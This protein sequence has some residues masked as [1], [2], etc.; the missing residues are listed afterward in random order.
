VAGKNSPPFGA[1]QIR[2]ADMASR[3]TNATRLV[4]AIRLFCLVSN[5]APQLAYPKS[6][7]EAIGCGPCI[8]GGLLVDFFGDPFMAS[9]IGVRLFFVTML[10]SGLFT[11]PMPACCVVP[12]F[13]K[14]VVN[15]DQTVVIVWDAA[16]R[17]QHFIRKASFQSEAD[18]FGFIVPSP[19]QPELEESGN[20]A[21]PYLQTLTEPKVIKLPRPI[22]IGCGH[23][24]E[25]VGSAPGSSYVQ[26]V[27]VLQETEVAGFNAVVLETKSSEAL[28]AWLKE[29]GYAFSPEVAAWAKPYVEGGWKFTALKI[30]KKHSSPATAVAA[31]SLR[32][33]FKTE[34]PLFP[35]REP[36]P[37]A[38]AQALGVKERLLRIYFLAEA[39]YRG[40]L[41][42]EVPWTGQV[43]WAG[44]LTPQTCTK[45]REMLKLP[46][47][48]GSASWWLTE[49]ED[50]WPYRAA[51]ADLYFSR[52]PNQHTLHRR[53]IIQ[54]V[55]SGWPSDVS[56][57]AIAAVVVLPPLVRSVRRKKRD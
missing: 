36:D 56:V 49:F 3:L 4:Q 54:Y 57:Y 31:A 52:D 55:S 25:M 1:K 20:D 39:R 40:Q 43:A 12:A 17:A 14:A 30:S 6:L 23:S 48:T 2:I 47:N 29:H 33:T 37:K 41:T 45:L 27:T 24:L 35:Y 26:G 13:G 8:I 53:A 44:K 9:R 5:S 51:P 7:A 18:D 21:F 10:V 16:T 32:I 19:S 15:A 50:R 11:P 42:K 38:F 22:S 46:A 28:T 34:R